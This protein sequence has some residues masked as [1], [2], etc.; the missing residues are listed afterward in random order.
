MVNKNSSKWNLQ[1]GLL[2]FDL[3]KIPT[4]QETDFPLVE[5]FLCDLFIRMLNY[6]VSELI[7]Y[8]SC[9]SLMYHLH[10]FKCI[11]WWTI[12]TQIFL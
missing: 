5:L 8:S 12:D 4:T 3:L 6:S 7:K 9:N 1:I 2:S 10:N 11:N